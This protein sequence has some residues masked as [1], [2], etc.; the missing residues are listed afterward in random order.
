M[1]F[2]QTL[3]WD[4]DPKRI[5]TKKNAKYI[6]ERIADFGHDNEARWVL[7]FYSKKL[8]KSVINSSRSI[9]PSTKALWQLL[10][11]S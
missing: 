6:I 4:T 11:K 8:L 7:D 9:R 2:R 1:K 5:D 10:L 3:F